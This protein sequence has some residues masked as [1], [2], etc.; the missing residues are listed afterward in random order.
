M[1]TPHLSPSRRSEATYLAFAI[2]PLALV[3]GLLAYGASQQ[4]AA[5]RYIE[6][7]LA[8]THA[9]GVTL[10]TRAQRVA[11]ENDLSPPIDADWRDLNEAISF[12]GYKYDGAFRLLDSSKDFVPA[13]QPWPAE[14]LTEAYHRDAAPLIERMRE[15]VN[16]G[17]REQEDGSDVSQQNAYRTAV[18]HAGEILRH[19][20]AYAYH[21]GDSAHAADLLTLEVDLVKV[22]LGTDTAPPSFDIIHRS[23]EHDFWK[24]D[25]LQRLRRLLNYHVDVEAR[26]RRRIDSETALF[27]G[28]VGLIN[29]GD[30]FLFR[31]SREDQPFGSP[32]TL[33]ASNLRVYAKFEKLQD[34]GTRKQVQ[35][36]AKI[37]EWWDASRPGMAIRGVTA[38]PFAF[39]DLDR[40][41][42]GLERH[43]VDYALGQVSDRRVLTAVA[44]KQFQLQEGR[45]PTSLSELSKVGLTPADWE[46]VAGIDFGY[47]VDADGKSARLWQSVGRN[48]GSG[49]SMFAKNFQFSAEPPSENYHGLSESVVKAAETVI[50]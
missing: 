25:D 48:G 32:P 43:S 34:A 50:R 18:W 15:L 28:E 13:S 1:A 31:S 9:D 45:W 16:L 38:I 5:H 7:Q 26:W 44:I 29:E 14:K 30:V 39:T 20:F 33:I 3:F 4:R 6:T 8:A 27:V 2:I 11:R 40:G 21:K 23:L 19:E 41:Y 49:E 47:R 36:A 22:I 12:L 24:A 35:A 37:R 17:K 46:M 42:G 10:E